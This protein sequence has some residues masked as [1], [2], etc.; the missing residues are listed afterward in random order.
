MHAFVISYVRTVLRVLSK[1]S[2]ACWFGQMLTK[3]IS[4]MK[5]LIASPTP[6]GVPVSLVR[7]WIWSL[8]YILFRN[9]NKIYR[10]SPRRSMRCQFESRVITLPTVLFHHH[11]ILESV[12][13]HHTI[14]LYPP[15]CIII[16]A[17]VIICWAALAQ[18]CNISYATGL[19]YQEFVYQW[20]GF[21][22]YWTQKTG[23]S[24]NIFIGKPVVTSLVR[25][26]GWL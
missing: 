25:E 13:C 14:V 11:F 8:Y 24:I 2:L 16:G 22:S 6:R 12:V 20:G 7:P 17:L 19:L 26:P 4:W 10:A 9:P 23:L 21:L 3:A 1:Y 18:P 5:N 15:L